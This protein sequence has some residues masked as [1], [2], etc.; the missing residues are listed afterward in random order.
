M[1]GQTSQKL[2]ETT[3]NKLICIIP[4]FCPYKTIE[5]SVVIDLIIMDDLKHVL[6]SAM[7]KQNLLDITNKK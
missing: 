3:V 4:Q 1:V 7:T 2:N 6:G 5:I